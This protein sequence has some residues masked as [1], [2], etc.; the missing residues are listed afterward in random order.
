MC[1]R[2]SVK[3]LLIS[4]PGDISE[5]GIH[6]LQ[7]DWEEAFEGTRAGEL[8]TVVLCDGVSVSTVSEP[9]GTYAV[10]PQPTPEWL[11]AYRS[12]GDGDDPRYK[13]IPL[14]GNPRGAVAQALTDDRRPP[15]PAFR[16]GYSGGH[17]RIRMKDNAPDARYTV[18][19]KSPRT[20]A[21]ATGVADMSGGE[22][23]AVAIAVRLGDPIEAQVIIDDVLVDSVWCR[24][25]ADVD[26][27]R[28]ADGLR[29][30]LL[31]TSPSPRDRTRSR[32][33]SSA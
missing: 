10:L 4:V 20:G 5:Q 27:E 29:D 13:A 6:R 1:I 19:V 22:E 17:M 31:Y 21:E 30:C 11:D 25:V 3:G 14:S 16:W 24:A 9:V 18:K 32:M 23:I 8:P 12:A 2:D 26:V 28:L 33:P 15:G 7:Q